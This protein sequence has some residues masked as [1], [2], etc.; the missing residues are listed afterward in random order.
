MKNFDKVIDIIRAERERQLAK[1]GLQHHDSF[2]WLAILMEEVGEASE[3]ALHDVFG[4]KHA[5][6]FKT[7]M[8]HVAA[9]AVQILE[10]LVDDYE[11]GK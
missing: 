8:I 1:W 11:S 5:G 2:R 6:T 4:G 3:A 10:W 9:V 7:E